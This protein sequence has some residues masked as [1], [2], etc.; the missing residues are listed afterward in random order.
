MCN[1]NN[2]YVSGKKSCLAALLE[3]TEEYC[4][5]CRKYHAGGTDE[6]CT[7][8]APSSYRVINEYKSS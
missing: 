7:Q 2:P 4:G 6:R 1:Y 3:N 8:N 5:K